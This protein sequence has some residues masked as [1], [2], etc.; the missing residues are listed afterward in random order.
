MRCPVR[1]LKNDKATKISD[2]KYRDPARRGREMF[3]GLNDERLHLYISRS[4]RPERTYRTLRAFNT[5]T[6]LPVAEPL[7]PRSGRAVLGLRGRPVAAIRVG[8]SLIDAVD[9]R[10]IRKQDT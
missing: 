1:F 3:E 8:T 2:A 5:P 7:R 10:A 9:L 6:L 4:L